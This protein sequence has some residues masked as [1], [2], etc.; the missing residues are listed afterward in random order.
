MNR[1]LYADLIE[2]IL[3]GED[4]ERIFALLA[5]LSP[6]E[7]Q[8][9]ALAASNLSQLCRMA[10]DATEDDESEADAQPHDA[11][12]VKARSTTLR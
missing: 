6:D 7:L 1:E 12:S 10:W 8:H 11:A 9:L 5:H 3:D 4:D 2:D